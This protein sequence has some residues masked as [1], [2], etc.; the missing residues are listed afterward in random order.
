MREDS[1]AEDV[2]QEAYM[3]AYRGLLKFR[4]EGDGASRNPRNPR[5]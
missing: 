1:E 3:R 2:L 5:G 4:G